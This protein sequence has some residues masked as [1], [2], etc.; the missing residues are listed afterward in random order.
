LH[1]KEG[2]SVMVFGASG[3]IGHLAVQ[4]AKR[5]GA[6][7]FAVASGDDGVK[8][9]E[10]LG[11]DAVVNGRKDDIQAAARKFAPQGLDAALV[12]AGGNAAEKALAAV[13]DGGRIAYP[14]GV[15][16]EPKARAGV[17]VL[18]YDG[19]PDRQALKKLNRLIESGPFEAHV[20]RIFPL[21]KAA[22]AHRAL[23]EHNLGKLG[24]RPS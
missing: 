19:T 20:A 11:A 2:E 12:T 4:L 18:R 10:R 15:E 22:A 13:R 5:M 3:G 6:R 16:P 17:S 21:E 8:F 9:V 14:T 1:L 23:D 24:L 7:V